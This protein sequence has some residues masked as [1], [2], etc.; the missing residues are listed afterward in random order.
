MSKI[1]FTIEVPKKKQRLP[2]AKPVIRFPDLKKKGQKNA[3]RSFK[4]S[5]D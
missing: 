4:N 2:F 1:L 5:I 3:C